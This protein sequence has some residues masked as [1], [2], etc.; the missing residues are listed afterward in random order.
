MWLRKNQ[1]PLYASYIA[2]A[3]ILPKETNNNRVISPGS[4]DLIGAD[5]RKFRF[6]LVSVRP[7]MVYEQNAVFVPAF[8]IDPILPVSIR[9]DIRYPDGTI[10]TAEG[11]ADRFGSFAGTERWPLDQP[12]VYVY[13]VKTD[14]Q[15]YP[16]CVP[17]LPAEGGYLF[18]KEKIAPAGASGL[19]LTLPNQQVFPVEKGLTI[20]GKSTAEIVFFAAVMPGAVVDQGRIPVER[21]SFKYHFDS[22]AL[23]RRMPIYDIVNQRSGRKEIGRVIHLTFFSCEKS[24]DLTPYHAFARVIL[25]G[26]T[27]IYTF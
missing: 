14:W 4:E 18:V 1:T 19:K 5:G 7:G 26:N 22:E 20:E 27:A 9:F 23:N 25:R 11:T 15:G 21:G 16:G 12:G 17:G 2:S 24:P 10:K 8:Q 13:T 6:F 3:F